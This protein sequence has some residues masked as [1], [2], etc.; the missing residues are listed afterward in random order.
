MVDDVH[1]FGYYL[2][3]IQTLS[4]LS[5]ISD[6]GPDLELLAPKIQPRTL[7]ASNR[8]NVTRHQDPHDSSTRTPYAAPPILPYFAIGGLITVR[9]QRPR[10][11]ED[12]MRWQR[13]SF[14]R[15]EVVG[16]E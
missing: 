3:L 14:A 4:P 10:E 1:E 2:A 12:V 11:G 16:S 9:P 6:H 13:S 8:P 5:Q 7:V 15:R